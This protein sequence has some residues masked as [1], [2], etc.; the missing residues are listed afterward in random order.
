MDSVWVALVGGLRGMKRLKTD[1]KHVNRD[2]QLLTE[3]H[4]G[5]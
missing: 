5:I 2:I 4:E 1:F 3:D